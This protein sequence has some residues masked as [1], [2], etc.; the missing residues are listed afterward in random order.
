MNLTVSDIHALTDSPQKR[1][2]LAALSAIHRQA[3]SVGETCLALAASES[4]SQQP[5]HRQHKTGEP[6]KT[7]AAYAVRLRTQVKAGEIR[8]F[9]FERFKLRLALPTEG[10]RG[11]WYAPDF[12][13]FAND[14][15]II[16]DEIKGGW[17]TEDALI[18]WKWAAEQFPRF[19]FRLWQKVGGGFEL[20]SERKSVK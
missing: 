9:L 16:F 15:T 18:K 17:I 20:K 3:V 12:M 4:K 6:N 8:G 5:D 7:E 11:C 2:L 10:G 1:G 14:G 13:V 19:G